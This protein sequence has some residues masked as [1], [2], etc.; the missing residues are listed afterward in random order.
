MSRCRHFLL[1]AGFLVGAFFVKAA[2]PKLV[3]L[4][5][6]LQPYREK[7]E[8]T[9]PQLTLPSSTSKNQLPTPKG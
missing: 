9:L 8:A 6:F 2:E 3:V 5:P 4:P 7:I 1:A